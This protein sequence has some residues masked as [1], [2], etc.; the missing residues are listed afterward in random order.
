MSEPLV[1]AICLTADRPEM[2]K[3]AVQSFRAQTYPNKRML[4]WDTSQRPGEPLASDHFV[5]W[6]VLSV[7]GLTIGELRNWANHTAVDLGAEVLIH[8]DSDDLSRPER[9][10][11]QVAHLEQ[12]GADA[13]GYNIVPFWRDPPGEA[14]LYTNRNRSYGIGASLAYRAEYW[15]RHAFAALPKTKG[16]TGEDTEFVRNA[17][18]SGVSAISNSGEPRLICLI[19]DG[20]TQY[21]GQDLLNK[22]VNWKRI[23]DWDERI[24]RFM[25]INHNAKSVRAGS[26]TMP[27]LR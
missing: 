24:A 27:P 16:G 4:I 10:S 13:V 12:S 8:W 11:E 26:Q 23:P 15:Q 6:H 22:S 25:E 3:R 5:V 7:P 17:G 14:W 1:C 2:T 18:M 21:Y 20:N 9:I 19:H